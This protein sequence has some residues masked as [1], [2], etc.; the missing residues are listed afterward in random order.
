MPDMDFVPRK[1]LKLAQSRGVHNDCIAAGVDG[2]CTSCARILNRSMDSFY[3]HL[4]TN[5]AAAAIL[6]DLLEEAIS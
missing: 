2:C 5:N 1:V 3:G 6:S 4:D